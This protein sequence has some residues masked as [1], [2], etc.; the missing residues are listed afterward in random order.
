MMLKEKDIERMREKAKIRASEGRRKRFDT[1]AQMA[2]VRKTEIDEEG[3]AL[4]GR[5]NR[6]WICGTGVV[7]LAVSAAAAA[8]FAFVHRGGG[9][10][11]AAASAAVASSDSVF[12]SAESAE[13][14]GN[15]PAA[16]ENGSD[17]RPVAAAAKPAVS[18]QPP[19]PAKSP[20]PRRSVAKFDGNLNDL[21]PD[22]RAEVLGASGQPPTH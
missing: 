2:V 15:P 19:S 6:A 21:P 12:E 3:E 10:E 18:A 5:G 14:R 9:K 20:A 1:L 8:W 13:T 17:P 7:L 4:N 16:V 22:V 11:D